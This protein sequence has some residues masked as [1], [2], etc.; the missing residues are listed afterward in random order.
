M[1]KRPG[2]GGGEQ[3][4]RKRVNERQRAGVGKREGLGWEVG[5]AGDERAKE[6]EP[7]D[8]KEKEMGGGW[9]RGEPG[10]GSRSQTEWGAGLLSPNRSPGSSQLPLSPAH[11]SAPS[12]PPPGSPALSQPPS[13]LPPPSLLPSNPRPPQPARLSCAVICP[14]PGARVVLSVCPPGRSP[15]CLW[16]PI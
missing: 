1:H 2:W 14:Q 8:Q 11:S 13:M 15:G 10:R 5:A 4:K 6:K 12:T 7:E 16:P 9:R 3:S